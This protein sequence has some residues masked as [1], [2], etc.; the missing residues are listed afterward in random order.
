MRALLFFFG[1]M[2]TLGFTGAQAADAPTPQALSIQGWEKFAVFQNQKRLGAMKFAKLTGQTEAITR[3][4]QRLLIPL[5]GGG[6]LAV[7]GGMGLGLGLWFTAE[8]EASGFIVGAP[9]SLDLGLALN[10]L[11]LKGQF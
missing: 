2:L 10:G 3:I 11:V 1:L 4:R 6:L 7:S 5:I 9:K 8:S